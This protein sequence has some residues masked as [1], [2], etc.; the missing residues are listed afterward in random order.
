MV[1]QF[2]TC[3]LES[4]LVDDFCAIAWPKVKVFNKRDVLDLPASLASS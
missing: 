3:L 1:N 4:S 2:E